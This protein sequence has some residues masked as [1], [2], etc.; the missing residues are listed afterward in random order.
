[1]NN[2]VLVTTKLHNSLYMYITLEDVFSV[3]KVDYTVDKISGENN[4]S[5]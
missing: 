1:M 2:P 5:S 3:Q 4:T